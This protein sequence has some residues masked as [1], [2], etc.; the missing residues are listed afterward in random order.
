MISARWR[1]HSLCCSGHP[2]PQAQKQRK[3]CVL[4]RY[5]CCQWT[6]VPVRTVQRNAAQPTSRNKQRTVCRCF[7]QEPQWTP[8]KCYR[9]KRA[10]NHA[11]KDPF[12][13]GLHTLRHHSLRHC[14]GRPVILHAPT[15]SHVLFALCWLHPLPLLAASPLT[16]PPRLGQTPRSRTPSNLQAFAVWLLARLLAW[17]FFSVLRVGLGN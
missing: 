9:R 11:A 2:R 4:E 3:H 14:R 13:S 8:L 6:R 1:G 10:V 16:P 5:S 7:S 12:S 15:R 17:A